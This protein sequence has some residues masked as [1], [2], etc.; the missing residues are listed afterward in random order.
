M[1]ELNPLTDLGYDPGL[2]MP[3]CPICGGIGYI[4][5]D[6]Q[7]EHP[8][9]GSMY[10]CKNRTL[11]HWDPK[12]GISKEEARF[13]DWSLYYKTPAVLAMREAIEQVLERRFGWIYIWGEPGNGKTITIKSATI[14]AARAKRMN[15]YY[16]RHS[17]LLNWLRESYDHKQGQKEYQT[18]ISD[19]GKLDFLAIDELGRDRQTEFSIQAL[20]AIMDLRYEGAINQR[21]ITLWVSN[22]SP[23]E[24]LEPYQ[25]DRVNDGRFIVIKVTSASLRPAMK[26]DAVEG[27]D[28]WWNRD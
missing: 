23:A 14:L 5:Y 13:R 22:Q 28:K 18:R 26:Y 11:K 20:S 9:F 19:I 25:L 12:I 27:E 17:D 1:P 4:K 3:N 8:E 24:I 7:V 2:C 15:A 6:R 21:G 10:P 16:T